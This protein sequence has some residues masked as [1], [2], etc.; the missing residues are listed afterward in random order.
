MD[1][2]SDLPDDDAYTIPADSLTHDDFNIVPQELS[3]TREESAASPMKPQNQATASKLASAKMAQ[4]TNLANN[5]KEEQ[6]ASQN[7]K[8][9]S[10]IQQSP[11]QETS[12]TEKQRPQS[13]WRNE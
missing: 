7:A 8:T 10:N 5:D 11:A 1:D 12:G 13:D 6:S 3:D 2:D 9:S 4:E